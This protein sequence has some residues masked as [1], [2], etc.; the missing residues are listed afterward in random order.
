M[1]AAASP[2][3][4]CDNCRIAIPWRPVVSR[5][6]T[7]CC[8]GCA[9]N[10]PCCCSYDPPPTRSGQEPATSPAPRSGKEIA[11]RFFEDIFSGTE[12]QAT[13]QLVAPGALVHLPFGRFAGPEGVRRLRSSLGTA[14][15]DLSFELADLIGEDDRVA[16][17]W[18]MRGTE[19]G[20]LF[21]VP[22]SGRP[23]TI[24]GLSLFRIEGERIVEHW[25]AEC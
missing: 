16:A 19:R 3:P 14:Y 24:T 13:E 22:P 15:P 10:G 5:G 1:N 4:R 18:V 17:R 2:T 23:T 7:Y 8:D 21:G 11:R 25:M 9:N 6:K 12:N 20:E